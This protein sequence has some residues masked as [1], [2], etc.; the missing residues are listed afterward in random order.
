VRKPTVSKTKLKLVALEW[1]NNQ[2]KE[3]LKYYQMNMDNS[4]GRI[5]SIFDKNMI[6][7]VKAVRA[8]VEYAKSNDALC[9]LDDN[10]EFANLLSIANYDKDL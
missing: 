1:E 3:K 5:K 2:L 9:V 10:Q 6:E 7:L 8:F 4:I